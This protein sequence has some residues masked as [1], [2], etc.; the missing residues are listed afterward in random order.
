MD[1]PHFRTLRIC[2]TTQQGGTQTIQQSIYLTHNNPC[3]ANLLVFQEMGLTQ[4]R[5]I[6]LKNYLDAIVGSEE[7]RLL[8]EDIR[9]AATEYISKPDD[10]QLF[11]KYLYTIMQWAKKGISNLP[12]P[13]N[14][15]DGY[16][17][18]VDV[19]DA[20]GTSYYDSYYPILEIIIYTS[21][22]DQYQLSLIPLTPAQPKS[23]RNPFGPLYKLTSVPRN[24]P[25]IN[26]LTAVG[27]STLLSNFLYNQSTSTET[28][29]AVASLLIDSANTR[30]FGI[31]KY[32]FSARQNVSP[33]GGIVYNCVNFIDIRTIPDADGNTTL[34]E[35][36]F[37]RLSLNE[38]TYNFSTPVPTNLSSV[39]ENVS[40][41][42]DDLITNEE[43]MGKVVRLVNDDIENLESNLELLR[44]GKD[45]Q[46]F[47]KYYDKLIGKD[48]QKKEPI[49]KNE[50]TE[51]IAISHEHLP[52]T[53]EQ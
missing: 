15:Y 6:D 10:N 3:G 46:V 31:P 17:F 21:N 7:M 43:I 40:I 36:I 45:K 50:I 14:Y 18:R 19:Y 44:T 25:F 39:N 49:V 41:D 22:T 20:S 37:F 33:F 4:I 27:F 13:I 42:I 35:S 47:V 12:V 34:V 26:D 16:R 29:M 11:Y 5:Y 28:Q 9:V 23:N 24:I 2:P 30:T 53:T 51:E 38:D 32:G 8:F 52:K 1:S 48:I